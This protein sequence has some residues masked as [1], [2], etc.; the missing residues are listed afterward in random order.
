M[1]LTLTYISLT[2]LALTSLWMISTDIKHKR[3]PNIG[4][5]A[6]IISALT[7]HIST[8]F[9]TIESFRVFELNN[10]VSILLA[11]LIGSC[12]LALIRF[13][14]NKAYQ[15]ETLGMGDIKLLFAAGLWVGFP[16]IL[17]ILC[18]GAFASALL[19]VLGF[20]I[21]KYILKEK[22]A[23]LKRT[24]IAAGPGFIMALLTI[25][26]IQNITLF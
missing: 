7:Y 4:V 1:L 21:K 2:T 23:T 13:F 8:D 24:H 16:Y 3:L 12:F 9:Q 22:K 14:A 20:C 25:V 10:W 18:F 15:Q 11:A 6:L 19:G 5:L 26:L 17:H